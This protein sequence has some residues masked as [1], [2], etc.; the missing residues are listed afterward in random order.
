MAND[1]VFTDEELEE[2][3]RPTLD[4]LLEAIEAG[5]LDKAKESS[6]RMYSESL[7]FH[8]LACVWLAAFMSE[9]YENHGEEAFYRAMRRGVEAYFKS[10]AEKLNEA[11]FRTRV[12]M[13]A[14]GFRSHLNPLRVV[15]DNEKVSMQ[16]IPCGSGQRLLKMGCYGPSMNCTMMQ[17]PHPMTYGMTDFPI[18]CTHAPIQEILAIEWFGAPVYITEAPDKMA[19]ESCWHHM[20]KD[21]RNVPDRYYDRV[22]KKKPKESR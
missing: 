19:R 7:R 1:R 8:D 4:V 10:G 17:S 20:Y 21:F 6:N 2:M 13:R 5:D 11:D 3:G 9:V 15:E 12:Q 18:Y 22:G 16:M 14:A